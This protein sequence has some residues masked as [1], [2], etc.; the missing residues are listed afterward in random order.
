VCV[1]VGVGFVGLIVVRVWVWVGVGGIPIG[2][3]KIDSHVVGISD[4]GI[5]VIVITGVGIRVIGIVCFIMITII[6][7][8]IIVNIRLLCKNIRILIS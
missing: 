7:V 8:T 1:H 3:M 2:V 5:R 6:K 4:V